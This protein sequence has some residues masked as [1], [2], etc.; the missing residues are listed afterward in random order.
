VKPV[1]LEVI[2]PL[3]EGLGTCAACELVMGEASMGQSPAERTTD[4]YPQEWREDA[5][6]LT[7]WVHDLATRY[8]DQVVI[9][10]IDPRSPEGLVKSVRYR[11][12]RYPTWVVNGSTRVVGWDRQ[13]LEAALQS[14]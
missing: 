5:Q 4:E 3:L 10:V 7:D 14:P 2:A 9:K 8:S 6:R 11:I 13:A 12:R 1:R